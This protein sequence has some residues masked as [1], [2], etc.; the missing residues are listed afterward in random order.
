MIKSDQNSAQSNARAFSNRLSTT[1]TEWKYGTYRSVWKIIVV[2]Q[3]PP[4]SQLKN[5][6]ISELSSGIYIL[7]IL[8]GNNVVYGKVMKE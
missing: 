3:I 7:K 5:V 2:E 1:I 6:D 8:W 4:W